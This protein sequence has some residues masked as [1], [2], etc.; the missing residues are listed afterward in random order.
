MYLL[1]LLFGLSS[2]YQII[3]SDKDGETDLCKSVSNVVKNLEQKMTT[4]LE[5]IL[6]LLQQRKDNE[7]IKDLKFV[8]T[9]QEVA[10]GKSVK[11]SSLYQGKYYPAE[12]AVDGNTGTFS[13]TKTE[14]NPYWWVDLG[15]LYKVKQIVVYSRT[16]CCGSYLKNMDVTVGPS[17]D[18]MSLCT[19]Y[20]GPASTGEHFNLDCKA[21]MVGRYV[22]LSINRKNSIMQ[23]AELKVFAY[24]QK[25]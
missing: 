3:V 21:A 4:Q 1:C 20:K 16:N 15:K 19:H 23:L 10:E 18:N 13:H 11:Q 12:L 9:L 7:C 17:L 14:E 2:A 8:E 24:R 22:K 6:T 25:I 5:Q